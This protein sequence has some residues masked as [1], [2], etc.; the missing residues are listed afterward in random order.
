MY[1]HVRGELRDVTPATAVVEAGGIGFDLRIPLS[2]FERIR[3]QRE[4]CLYTHF[5]VREDDQRLFGFATQGERELFRLLISVTGVGP[6]IAIQAMSALSPAEVAGAISQGDSKTLRRMK[7]VG[8]KL[9]ERL[10]LELRDRVGSLLEVL[11]ASKSLVAASREAS[12]PR[13]PLLDQPAAASA[14]LALVSL[15]F[16]RKQAEDRVADR[17]KRSPAAPQQAMDVET[18]I[19]ACLRTE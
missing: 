15:G 5:H 18:L 11:G 8:Q 3:G 13:D 6:T 4:V 10:V 17:L 7:G 19:K 16:E 9:A 1:H 2:T 14:V 12:P